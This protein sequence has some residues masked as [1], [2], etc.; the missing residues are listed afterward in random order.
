ML[1]NQVLLSLCSIIF[2][3]V[4]VAFEGQHGE[5]TFP[6]AESKRLA[7]PLITFLPHLIISP[8]LPRRI[9]AG[10]DNTRGAGTHCPG[11]L[12][13][14]D[15]GTVM[16]RTMPMMDTALREVSKSIFGISKLAKRER[17]SWHGKLPIEMVVARGADPIEYV[18][19][20]GPPIPEWSY[21]AV[22][23]VNNIM[24]PVS[25]NILR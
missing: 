16:R 17:E 9:V 15:V 10:V 8:S 19:G 3:R 6:R 24:G 23:T 25:M 18:R 21:T 4:F 7:N 12:C 14:D 5:D 22:Q 2:A 13:P 1:M 11:V 20:V